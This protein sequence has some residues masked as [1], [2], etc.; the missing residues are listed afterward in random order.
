MAELI[1][2]DNLIVFSADA[3]Q[4]VLVR[5]RVF[6]GFS[7]NRHFNKPSEQF[8]CIVKFM[9]EISFFQPAY[10]GIAQACAWRMT[11]SQIIAKNIY[12]SCI[13]LNVLSGFITRQDVAGRCVVAVTLKS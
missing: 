3:L 6:N 5:N 4:S 2:L 12:A 10:T 1:G 11:H 9:P 7:W 13:S 8:R